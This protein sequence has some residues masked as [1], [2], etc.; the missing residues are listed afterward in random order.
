MGKMKGLIL[1]LFLTGSALMAQI[2]DVTKEMDW[3]NYDDRPDRG[4][5]ECR[6]S[7]AEEKIDGRTLTVAVMSGR[8]TTQFKYGYAGMGAK[9]KVELLALLKSGKGIKFRVIGDGK[10]Y[11]FKT[12]TSDV[13]DY[14]YFGR[15]F[16]TE[17]GKPL[18]IT[19][20]FDDL[21][22]EGWGQKLVFDRSRIWQLSWQ[23][24][25]Q[26]HE[27]ILLKIYDIRIIP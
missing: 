2:Q 20:L 17:P 16:E 22:Q 23:T 7:L 11:R 18:E 24:V 6:F 15:T 9:P 14:D 5:S 1:L 10:T 13:K 27:N 26:P 12:E 4:S 3:Y 19:V 21:A 25:G 8:V